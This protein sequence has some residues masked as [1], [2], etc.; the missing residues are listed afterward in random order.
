MNL[1]AQVGHG[2]GD[3][4]TMGLEEKLID[5]AIFSPKDLKRDTQW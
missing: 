2:M 4:V 1:F 5:G 3:K